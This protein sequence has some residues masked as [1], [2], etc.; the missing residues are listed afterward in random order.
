MGWADSSP[1]NVYES[2]MIR[3][4]IQLGNYLLFD[5]H[6]NNYLAI[7]YGKRRVENSSINENT[8]IWQAA[9]GVEGTAAALGIPLA[10]G[11]IGLLL[12][13]NDGDETKLSPE[14]AMYIMGFFGG[15]FLSFIDN[16]YVNFEMG[17]ENALSTDGSYKSGI[18][19]AAGMHFYF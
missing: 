18:K 6:M 15:I 10:V 7:G 4:V 13:N 5:R 16:A 14:E 19:V 2:F 1:G 12:I 9:L 8:E 11:S 3:P 17:Y